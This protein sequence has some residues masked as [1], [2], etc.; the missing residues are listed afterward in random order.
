VFIYEQG[1]CRSKAWGQKQGM[2][3][4]GDLRQDPDTMF[5][6]R[7][8]SEERTQI[9]LSLLKNALQ[10]LTD[11]LPP[12]ADIIFIV[13]IRCSVSAWPWRIPSFIMVA[14]LA[15]IVLDQGFKF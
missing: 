14:W 4:K 9:S 2:K 11:S 1:I 15:N 3:V 5:F 12:P 7:A 8:R 10:G 6:I 13:E